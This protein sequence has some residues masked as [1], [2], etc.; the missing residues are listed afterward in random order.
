[1]KGR[2][3]G[4]WLASLGNLPP[5]SLID[6][7]RRVGFQA[8]VVDKTTLA[9]APIAAIDNLLKS[10]PGVMAIQSTDGV[11]VAYIFPHGEVRTS[12]R[13][14]AAHGGWWPIPAGDAAWWASAMGQRAQIKLQKAG[15][16][17]ACRLSATFESAVQRKIILR[18][19][20]GTSLHEFML[21]PST[22]QNINVDVPAS[23]NYISIETDVPSTKSPGNDREVSFKMALGSGA[24]CA[25]ASSAIARGPT[26][27]PQK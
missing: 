14:V 5:A 9:V 2:A 20:G 26:S 15:S 6:A 21:I 1:M 7:V 13:A 4:N 25:Y 22:Q 23:T 12:A 3:E 17:D 27:L 24:S 18:G 11:Q 8:V 10:M 16:G 19:E